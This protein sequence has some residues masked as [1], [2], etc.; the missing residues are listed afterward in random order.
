MRLNQ[1]DRNYIVKRAVTARFDPIRESLK[2]EEAQLG[3]ELYDHVYSPKV[4][5]WTK[6]APKGWLYEDECLRFNL[7][8]LQVSV[9]VPGG[10]PVPHNGGSCRPQRI[11][12]LDED[13]R[14]RYLNLQDRIKA[15][16]AE[17]EQVRA[18]LVGMLSRVGTIAKLKEVWP[19]GLPFYDDLQ[20][21]ERIDV[22][23]LQV[24]DIN[25]MLGLAA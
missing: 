17:R 14:D 23:A 25:K 1:H 6:A 24:A 3:R 20:P 9:S 4:R 8:G 12:V 21:R 13:L 2:K 22:P 10:L 19:E 18:S 15:E 7:C 11:P 5:A 16:S